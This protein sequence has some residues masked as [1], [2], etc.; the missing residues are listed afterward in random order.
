[1]FCTSV[2]SKVLQNRDWQP[3]ARLMRGVE[4]A[5]LASGNFSA[6]RTI[7]ISI[8]RRAPLHADVRPTL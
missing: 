8:V 5:R 6:R 7:L 2:A 1:M 4:A 3:N